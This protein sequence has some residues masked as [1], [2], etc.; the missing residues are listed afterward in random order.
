MNRETAFVRV[1][2]EPGFKK[3]FIITAIPFKAVSRGF[4]DDA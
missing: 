4:F 3:P 1:K 2:R